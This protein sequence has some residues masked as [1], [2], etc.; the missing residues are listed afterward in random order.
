MMES[1]STIKKGYE[2]LAHAIEHGIDEVDLLRLKLALK[3]EISDQQYNELVEKLLSRHEKTEGPL[4]DVGIKLAKENNDLGIDP[5][6]KLEKN[7][8]LEKRLGDLIKELN[9]PKTK[10]NRSTPTLS[11]V[12]VVAVDLDNLKKWNDEY[13]HRFGDEALFVLTSSLKAS[14]RGG[15]FVFR[16]GDK[17]DEFIVLLRIDNEIDK[18]RI[19]QLFEII[20]TKANSNFIKV[21]GV[22]MPVTAAM[23]YIILKPGESREIKDILDVADLNQ[24]AEKI[25]EIKKRRIE[26]AGQRLAKVS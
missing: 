4:A 14:I 7:N 17:S 11:S 5:V 23:G 15:D 13:G 26:E 2:Y 20:K 25:P 16:R 24:V 8:L 3:G 1:K 21:D 6:T 18:D 12:V 9:F 10:E 19:N 22:D